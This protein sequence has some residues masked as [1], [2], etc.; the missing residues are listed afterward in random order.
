MQPKWHSTLHSQNKW[1]PTIADD[2]T[3]SKRQEQPLKDNLIK[4]QHVIQG[5]VGKDYEG[6][7]G[8]YDHQAYAFVVQQ[9]SIESNFDKIKA[10]LEMYSPRDIK[11]IQSLPGKIATISYFI[12]LAT[13]KCQPFFKALKSKQK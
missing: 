6:I 10:I 3:S 7:H 12:S 9:R 13:N 1:T 11:K 5:A 8:L 4:I 2:N